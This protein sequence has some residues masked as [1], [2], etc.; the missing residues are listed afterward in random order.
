MR[1]FVLAGVLIATHI[2][3][4]TLFEYIRIWGVAPNILVAIVV[5]FA[6]L[7]GSKEGA[8]IG[9]FGGVLYDV[10]FS[11]TFGS[12]IISYVLVGYCCGKLHPYCYRE[13]FILPFSCTLFGSLLVSLMNILGFILRGKLLFGFFLY[14]I[15]IPELIYTMT[16]TLMIYQLSYTINHYLEIREKKTRNMF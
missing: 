9:A 14:E 6:L 4:V 7:R 2:L 11:M 10:T 12:A 1:Y 13:N 3:Q 8:L 16:L 5:S 15:I